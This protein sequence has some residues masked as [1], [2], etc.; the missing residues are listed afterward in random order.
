MRLAA[1]ALLCLLAGAC[2]TQAATPSPTPGPVT[3]FDFAGTAWRATAIDGQE[4]P[5][6]LQPWIRI[7]SHGSAS[8]FSGCDDFLFGVTFGRGVVKV[9]DI[10]SGGNCDER[11]RTLEEA[12]TTALNSVTAWGVNADALTLAGNVRVI[13]LTRDLPPRGDPMRAVADRLHE[14]RWT[15]IK[16]TGVA[17]VDQTPPIRFDDRSLLASGE[18]GFS[19]WMRFEPGRLVIEEV[20][21]DLAGC[22]DGDGDENRRHLA[23]VL[24]AVTGARPGPDGTIVL[25]GA[26]GEVVLGP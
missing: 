7:N 24:N 1:A 17:S 18:C 13:Q 26:G 4:V 10:Q 15:V 20:G 22:F 2:G 6:D 12:F 5:A 8:G 14:R 21:W 16:A 9:T 25:F 3:E 11:G 23:S 19:S